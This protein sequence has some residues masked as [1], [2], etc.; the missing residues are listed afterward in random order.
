[1]ANQFRRL[2]PQFATTR[3]IAEITNTILN[4]KT[5]NTGTIDLATGGA[6]T[7]TLYNERISHD[8]QIVLLPISIAAS[9][10]G[11]LTPHGLFEHQSTQTFSANTAT[12]IALAT[13]ED[14][15][16]MSLASNQVTVDY[17]G[18]YHVD[19]CG[20]FTNDQSQI[21]EAYVWLRKNGTDVD[22]SC[23]SITIP[24]KQGSTDGAAH[25]VFGHPVELAASDYI[26]CVC[27]VD[28]ANVELTA[29]SA[30]TTPFIRP[31]IP[32]ATVEVSL[33]EPS[34][35]SGSALTPYVS[36]QTIGE[37]TITHLPNSVSNN[38]F[39]YII[40]G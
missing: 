10:A 23:Q 28:N 18:L 36:S 6:T 31:S 39:G 35:T 40:V 4:G 30:Q 8:S 3:E 7:T 15:Y 24:D 1:M 34:Q 13:T 27:A 17:A 21:H 14:A 38:T 37:A 19:F 29:E 26:E 9:G 2:Q 25:V 11:S 32:S 20:R 33:I 22:H 5:N 12:V 16:S